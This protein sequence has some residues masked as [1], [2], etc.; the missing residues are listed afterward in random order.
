MRSEKL[1]KT[2]K[3]ANGL[4]VNMYDQTKV[5]FGDYYRVKVTVIC[6]FED[7][8]DATGLS[9]PDNNLRA[10]S[11]TRTLEKMGVP[12]GDVERA[13]RTLLDDFYLNS[14]PYISS[15]EFPQ[16]LINNNRINTKSPVRK[17]TGSGS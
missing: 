10:V 1:L 9:F 5:Y 16:Q 14:L 6:A 11:Y 3:L 12:A 8:A 17:Y 15:Q 13:I 4:T 7:L 2:L